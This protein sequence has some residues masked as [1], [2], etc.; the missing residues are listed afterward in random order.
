MSV[1]VRVN[2]RSDRR[3]TISRGVSNGAKKA[4]QDITDNLAM[5]SS[6]S[7]PHDKGILDDSWTK[8]VGYEG[9]KLFG[10]V[11]YN[12]LENGSGGDYNYA[13]RMHEGNYEL[14]EGS[15]QKSGGSGM[16]GRTYPVGKHFL[17]GVLEGEKQT[18]VKHMEKGIK[19]EL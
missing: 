4:M 18:Y 5:A 12:V 13:I 15:R 19:N 10:R 17:T 14:G 7:A 2:I 8:E 1:N 11:S 6:G 16:S 9:N 3:A